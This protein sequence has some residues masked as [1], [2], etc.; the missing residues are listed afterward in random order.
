M[1]MWTRLVVAMRSHT[2]TAVPSGC[3]A[4]S[5]LLTPPRP[6]MVCAAPHVPALERTR[7]F[8]MPSL[9]RSKVT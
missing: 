5:E 7:S 4:K 1:R 8:M 9:R 6:E 3:T 2:K